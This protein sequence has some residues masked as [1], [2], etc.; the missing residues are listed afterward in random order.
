M[1]GRDDIGIKDIEDYILDYSNQS[2]D[3]VTILPQGEGCIIQMKYPSGKTY[4][5]RIPPEQIDDLERKIRKLQ[6]IRW[7]RRKRE[8]ESK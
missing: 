7:R 3:I 1:S 4:S 8:E 2:D 6:L 5:R